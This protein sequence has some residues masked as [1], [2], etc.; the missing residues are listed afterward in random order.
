MT[1]QDVL[2]YLIKRLNLSNNRQWNNFDQDDIIFIRNYIHEV[3][4]KMTSMESIAASFQKYTWDFISGKFDYMLNHMIDKFGIKINWV[5]LKPPQRNLF[6][7]EVYN[8]KV[9]SYE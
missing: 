2:N 8:F 3:T 7:T 1:R 5:E 4:G 9:A 6:G